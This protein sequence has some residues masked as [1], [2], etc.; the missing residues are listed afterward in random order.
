VNY[1]EV[2][3]I[4]LRGLRTN[5]LRSALTTLGIIIGVSSVI[6]LVALGNGL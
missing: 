2:L 3:W 1:Q 6:V 5:R 4:A